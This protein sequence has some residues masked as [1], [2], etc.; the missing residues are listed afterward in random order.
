MTPRGHAL[1]AAGQNAGDVEYRLLDRVPAC[2]TVMGDPAQEGAIARW[3][4][5]ACGRH[6]AAN[7]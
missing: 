3:G 1:S 7:A 2:G 5:W 4:R 6:L